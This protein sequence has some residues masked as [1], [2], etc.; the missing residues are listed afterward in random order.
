MTVDQTTSQ[1]ETRLPDQFLND[2]VGL[3]RDLM[4]SDLI[5]I[6]LYGS[7]ARGESQPGSDV[8]LLVIARNL[9]HG[10]FERVNYVHRLTVGRFRRRISVLAKEPTEFEGHFP[11]LYLDIGLDGIILYD[12]EGYMADKLARIREIIEEAGLYRVRRDGELMWL[13]KRQ[14]TLHWAIEWDGFH[15]SS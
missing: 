7:W 13:W 3:F 11:S 9:P 6:V 14:P 10:R 4:G 15:E 2:I 1:P 5:A 12:T 8:D